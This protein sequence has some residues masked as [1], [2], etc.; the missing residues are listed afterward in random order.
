MEEEF[1]KDNVEEEFD[2]VVEELTDD[3]FWGYVRSWFSED[4]ILDTMK[5]WDTETKKEAIDEMKEIIRWER[6]KKMGYVKKDE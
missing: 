2:K 1:D 6:W 3:E 4:F 5:N